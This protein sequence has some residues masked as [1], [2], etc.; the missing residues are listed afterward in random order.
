MPAIP[1]LE[2]PLSLLCVAP[3]GM[4]EGSIVDLEQHELA[5]VVGEPVRFRFFGSTVR[6]SDP[7]GCVHERYRQDEIHELS[8]IEITLPAQGR[9][10]GDVV[11]VR[12]RASVTEVGTLS[13]EAVPL[14]TQQPDEC[15]KIELSVR[16]SA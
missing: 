4:Q 16:E 11:P 6:R 9:P 10:E 5:V 2:P 12:L 1:G 3:F 15:W 7:A 8:P 14:E 13:L